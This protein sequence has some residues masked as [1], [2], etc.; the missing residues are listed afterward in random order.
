MKFVA[1]KWFLVSSRRTARARHRKSSAI[2]VPC[3]VPRAT[4][5]VTINHT[6][7]TLIPFG[8]TRLCVDFTSL[9][10]PLRLMEWNR[11]NESKRLQGANEQGTVIVYY[12]SAGN[13]RNIYINTVTRIV[14]VKHACQTLW[15]ASI[16]W[17]VSYSFGRVHWYI[18]FIQSQR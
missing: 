2:A 8:K 9:D 14:L 13:S 7:E 5:A 4:I 3:A 12:T 1:V 18:E 17:M 15:I 16:F 11:R 10:R 6:L